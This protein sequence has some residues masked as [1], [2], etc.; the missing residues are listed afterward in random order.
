MRIEDALGDVLRVFLDTAPA[1]YFLEGHPSYFTRMET[2]FRLRREKGIVVV[3]SPVTLAE[4][5]VYPIRRG[6]SPQI[7]Q[8]RRLIVAGNGVE[9]R[10][11]GSA[12]AE[13]AA[14]LRAVTMIPLMDALQVG[15][16]V[17]SGC[18]VFLT[19]DRRLSKLQ[20]IR[21]LVLD[22]LEV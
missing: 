13:R 6:L 2:F 17:D 19:N 1:I 8:F 9:F 16:A 15:V 12:A 10:G 21:F 7:E 14:Q 22:D 4:S 20:D 11:I 3:T 5:L 18:D